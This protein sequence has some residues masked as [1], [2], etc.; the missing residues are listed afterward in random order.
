VCSCSAGSCCKTGLILILSGDTG[1]GTKKSCKKRKITPDAK[2]SD[3]VVAKFISAIMRRGKRNVAEQVFYASMAQ[4]EE[5][6][7]SHQ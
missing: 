3:I 4:I 1:H 5:K 7:V 6:T 2:F